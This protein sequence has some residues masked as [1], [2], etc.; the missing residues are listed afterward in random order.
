MRA[1]IEWQIS[2]YFVVIEN[3]AADLFK[4]QNHFAANASIIEIP[5]RPL[6]NR[7][8]LGKEDLLN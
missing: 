1:S 8:I 3:K 2:S 7:L 4:K 5:A 6:N